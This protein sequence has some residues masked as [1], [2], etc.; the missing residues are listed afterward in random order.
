MLEIVNQLDGF[1]ARGNVK[2]RL[3]LPNSGRIGTAR[4]QPRRR[5]GS[6]FHALTEGF[7]GGQR[8]VIWV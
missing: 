5:V 3:T 4:H 1:D 6:W 2:V 7:G 8:N